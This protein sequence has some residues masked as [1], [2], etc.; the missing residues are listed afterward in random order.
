MHRYTRKDKRFYNSKATRPWKKLQQL[1]DIEEE[2]GIELVTLLKA[3][4]SDKMYIKLSFENN[5]IVEWNEE[6][7][8]YGN[9]VWD[10]PQGIV[11][12][13]W[14]YPVETEHF[15]TEIKNYGKTWALNKKE[16]LDE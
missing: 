12:F 9:I 15:V 14:S 13:Y 1:E 4:Q 5:L 2:I 16:L 11:Y 6:C 10:L 8:T 7:N 3:M